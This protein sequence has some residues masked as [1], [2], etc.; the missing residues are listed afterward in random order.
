MQHH[1]A[2]AAMMHGKLLNRSTLAVAV[3]GDREHICVLAGTRR[4][5]NVI[6]LSQL[7]AAHAGSHTAHCTNLVLVKADGLALVGGDQ[8][9]LLAVG[10]TNVNQ[11]VV[12]VEVERTQT[13][14][15]DVLQ[16]AQHDTLCNTLTG[17]EEQEL[18]VRKLLYREHCGDFFAVFQF[19][20]VNNVHALSRTSGLRN[21]VALQLVNLAAIREEQDGVMRGC[22]EDILCE[23]LLTGAHC[24]NT[25][26]AAAL[27]A[28]N[29]GRLA[30]DI[31]EVGEGIRAVLL[32]DEVLN[33]DL[34]S[35]ILNARMALVAVFLL[36]LLQLLLDNSKNIR[37]ARQNFLKAR[38]AALE[39]FVLV[40]DLLLLQTGQAAQTHIYDGLRLRLV[41]V[42]LEVLRAV[43]DAEQR[44][45]VDPER[46]RH[47]VFLGFGLV[48]GGADDGDN[49]VD[50][51]SCD[52]ETLQNVRTVARLL[53]IKA[54]AALDNVLLEADILIEDL[55]QRQHTRL[56]LAARTRH[57][58]DVDHRN[59]IL[60]L[61]I[62]EQLIEDDLRVRIAANIHDNLHTLARGM[63]LNVRD[64]VDALVF[65]QICHG[66][67]QT[68]LVYHVRD[69]CNN[70]LA[71]AVRQIYD[72]GLCA[73]FDLAA[74]GRVGGADAAAAHDNAA[75]R[76][77]RALDEL[78][79][80]VHLRLGMVDDIAGAV[81]DLREVVRRDVGRHADR[82]TGRAVYQQVGEAG[83]QYD[84]LLALLIEVRL[85]IDRVFLDIRQHVVCQLGH[86]GLGIT[87]CCRGVAV[88]GTEVAVT[89]DQ[90]IVQRE[91]LRHTHHRVIDRCVAV[92]MIPAEHITDGRC[93]LAV[94]LVRGQAV[95]VHRVQDTAVYRL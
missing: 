66:L 21:L 77:V 24:G 27:C 68:R 74:A 51:V 89:V 45:L 11:C 43:H 54:R 15:A 70:D 29:R 81:D 12:L 90:R 14:A 26:A 10:Q 78:A 7:D 69:F 88:H 91:R 1:A 36:D 82:D 9:V 33:V 52:L 50:I 25:A 84:R 95:L 87:V 23:V 20:Q 19:Q 67:D 83:R 38:N 48:L 5:D 13:R 55:A 64:T 42:E 2:A 59:G 92:R 61:R 18:I 72:L 94:G 60:E 17:D 28:V 53:E 56:Q 39:V 79:D 62:G 34:V 22:G 76:E 37:I 63:V 93:R 65:D 16:V 31:A 73:D 30:L 75:G 41:E 32:L 58:R 44:N 6:A 3:L 40:V 57:E 85:E 35:H 47:Q 46:L 80:L 86:A 8:D 49:A 4:A 71:L